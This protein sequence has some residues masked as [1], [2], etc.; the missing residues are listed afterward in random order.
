VRAVIRACL[1]SA[2]IGTLISWPVQAS[3][4]KPLGTITQA[5]ATWIDKSVAA[6]GTTVYPGDTLK[7]DDTGSI[8]MRSGLAQLYM[9]SASEAR[10][11]AVGKGIRAS[12]LKGTAGFSSGASD[13]VEFNALGVEI[14]S[15]DG[16]PAHGRVSIVGAN[17]LVVT[18]FRGPF[19]ATYD[20][21][22]HAIA[23]GSSYRLTLAD[24]DDKPGT[25]G[26]GTQAVRSRKKLL[27]IVLVSAAVVA[28]GVVSWVVY[29]E[30]TESPSK[31]TPQ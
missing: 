16:Q 8:R 28:A 1:I 4:T 15:L 29:D 12:L 11:E 7:T 5:Q 20:G 26:N 22:T 24:A 18:S 2:L 10:L 25:E 17:E 9:M 30:L 27:F 31:P 19:E 14:R 23:D 6:V 3:S 13:T 21:V